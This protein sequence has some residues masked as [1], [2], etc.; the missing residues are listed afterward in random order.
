MITTK[1]IQATLETDSIIREYRDSH[2]M[3]FSEDKTRFVAY[4]PRW[5]WVVH[6]DGLFSGRGKTL[7]EALAVLDLEKLWFDVRLNSIKR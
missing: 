7:E 1:Q 2:V 4:S 6:H 5:D 3:W